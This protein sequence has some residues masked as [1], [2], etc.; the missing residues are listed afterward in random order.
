MKHVNDPIPNVLASRPDT[1][2][3][4]ASLI[5]RSLAKRPADRPASMNE[6]VAELEAV[7]AELD[8]KEGGEGTMIMRKPAVV[9][10]R[11]PRPKRRAGRGTRR[12]PLWPLILAGLLILAVVGAIVLVTRGGDEPGAAADSPVRLQGVASFDPDGDREEHSE[13]VADATDGDAATYWTTE[14]YRAF[15]KPGVGLV[16]EAA[17]KPKAL[18][19]TTDTPGYTAEIR[20]GNSPD[21]PFDTVVGAPKATSETTS[22]ELDDTGARYLTIWIT[23]L[24]EVAHVNEVKAS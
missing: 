15:S 12:M 11:P 14:S 6:V 22:W 3:R 16:L 18:T 23:R 4:L 19:L 9:R 13:R 5:E 8:A 7:L 2:L 17:G 21:G 10:A 24:D 1:P 20:A